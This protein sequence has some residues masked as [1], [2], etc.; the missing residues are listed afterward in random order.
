MTELTVPGP[1]VV[2]DETQK[3]YAGIWVLKKMDLDVK[4]GG[5]IFPIKLPSDLSPLE[6]VLHDLA[7]R[8]L[9]VMNTRKDRYDLTK[10]GTALLA[11]L[12]DEAED[13]ID[14]F[15][16]WETEDVIAELRRRN[17][18]PLRARFLWGWFDGE[19]DD[20]VTWQQR[21]G[22][23]PVETLWAYYLTSAEFFQEL[24]RELE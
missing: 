15:D 20:L 19:F 12:I 13:L 5:M 1:V 10:Q 2:D 7:V 24:A 18:D 23:N 17:L 22:V 14:E 6:D 21:R 9:V 3:L 16:D 8:G 4:D 11:D